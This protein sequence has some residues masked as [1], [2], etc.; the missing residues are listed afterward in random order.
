MT[1]PTP[2]QD[3]LLWHWSDRLVGRP[4]EHREVGEDA[5][6]AEGATGL[7]QAFRGPERDEL[8]PLWMRVITGQS[9]AW[10]Y[11]RT[12]NR[13][14]ARRRRLARRLLRLIQLRRSIRRG[15]VRPRLRQRLGAAMAGRRPAPTIPEAVR[16]PLS[17]R[18]AGT[19][20]GAAAFEPLLAAGRDGVGVGIE[21]GVAAPAVQIATDSPPSYVLT[22]SQRWIAAYVPHHHPP[23]GFPQRP[24]QATMRLERLDEQALAPRRRRGVIAAARRYRAFDCSE[25]RLGLHDAARLLVD[26]GGAGTPLVAARGVPSEV[27]GLLGEEMVAAI[28]ARTP[29]DLRDSLERERH[30]VRLRRIVHRHHSVYSGL[31]LIAREAGR[32][33]PTSPSVTVLMATN[34]SSMVEFAVGQVAAQNY[35]SVELICGL[36]GMELA[37]RDAG[38]LRELHPELQL[39]PIGRDRD[40]G[41]NLAEL[42][43]LAGGDLITKWDDD[44]WYGV[45]H[46]HDL[47]DALRYSGAALV[48]KA[49]EFVYLSSLGCTVR[50]FATGSESFS[51]TVAGGTLMLRRELLAELGGWPSGPRRVDRLLIE[52]I[53]SRGGAVY[54]THG[55]GYVLR[56][57]PGLTAHTWQVDEDYF[58]AQAVEQRPGLDLAF[59]GVVD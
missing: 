19:L 20:D 18:W 45:E 24:E 15:S 35:P 29:A 52:E 56:R 48:G 55:F 12:R 8:A 13:L 21:L 17:V 28:E 40:L 37:A 39:V 16:V 27:A 7:G 25:T 3:R 36:H 54:R 11:R 2:G 23:S 1:A 49:A 46:L 43:R 9:F 31:G 34:R 44:D 51:T 47:V 58:L 53:E 50:R 10:R 14:R 38:R 5:R 26:L 59:A 57:D 4:A 32:V 41:Q 42:A 33:V 30:S 22:A 6:D